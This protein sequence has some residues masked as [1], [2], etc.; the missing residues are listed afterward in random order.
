MNGSFFKTPLMEKMV[1]I[2]GS[3]RYCCVF[4][5]LYV[6]IYKVFIS[7][8]M[9]WVHELE[10]PCINKWYRMESRPFLISSGAG[11]T[12]KCLQRV[13]AAEHPHV[14]SLINM[15]GFMEDIEL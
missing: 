11:S 6:Y 14:Y 9:F 1:R 3:H 8:A 12:R 10:V 5:V 4:F 7:L 13:V 2:P 15:K